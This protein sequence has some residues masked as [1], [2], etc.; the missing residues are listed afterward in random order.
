VLACFAIAQSIVTPG[1][2]LAKLFR[3][4]REGE[5]FETY[6]GH[7]VDNFDPH[8]FWFECFRLLR[9]TMLVT[10]VE[11]IN[12]ASL[13]AFAATIITTCSMFVTVLSRPYKNTWLSAVDGTGHIVIILCIQI[14]L[15]F[16]TR[17]QDVAETEIGASVAIVL[18]A[19]GWGLFLLY[20]LKV[21]LPQ[22]DAQDDTAG[23]SHSGSLRG[24]FSALFRASLPHEEPITSQELNQVRHESIMT[25]SGVAD[26]TDG[27]QAA[28]QPDSLGM[29]FP[30]C[31]QPA[32]SSTASNSAGWPDLR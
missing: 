28:V 1:V 25:M 7:W 30:E 32:P 16:C 5:E 6:W 17:E 18:L 10:V 19:V 11:L 26:T 24:R 12:T 8:A 22:T 27:G 21:T 15:A 2:I 31:P 13:Q 4:G 29:D 9:K 20:L 23:E 3:S 14:G